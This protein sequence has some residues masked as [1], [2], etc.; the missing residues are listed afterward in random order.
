MLRRIR[1]GMPGDQMSGTWTAEACVGRADR[2]QL[3]ASRTAATAPDPRG[4]GTVP[5]RRPASGLNQ[6]PARPL[7]TDL[8]RPGAVSRPRATTPCRSP[9]SRRSTTRHALAGR[10]KVTFTVAP[11]STTFGVTD[12]TQPPHD[13]A[14]V[15]SATNNVAGRTVV[16]DRDRPGP[17]VRRDGTGR[18]QDGSGSGSASGSGSGSG[19]GGLPTRVAATRRQGRTAP[20][21]PSRHTRRPGSRATCHEDGAIEQ[22]RGRASCD[23]AWSRWWSRTRCPGRTARRPSCVR[24]AAPCHPTT[25]W[26]T[27]VRAR[28]G[29]PRWRS[30]FRSPGRTARRTSRARPPSRTRP[31]AP[32]HRVAGWPSMAPRV[33][34]ACSRSRSTSPCPD[35]TA[36]PS[37][38]GLSG[39]VA[40]RHEHPAIGQQD[41]PRG[42]GAGRIICPGGGPGP[43]VGVVQLGRRRRPVTSTLP[44][45]SSVAERRRPS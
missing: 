4:L 26:P 33:G 10:R 15:S 30:R 14:R 44:S 34:R 13:A 35:R 37:L 3:A 24:H 1:A 29:I 32:C 45:R 2:R 31:R 40:A 38:T 6:P 42:C 9:G 36:R 21:S 18:G 41:R 43:A 27:V 19:S 39:D 16:A 25:A 11:G 7:D 17:S 20:P 28:P 5:N 22:Q 8:A 23:G 12:P